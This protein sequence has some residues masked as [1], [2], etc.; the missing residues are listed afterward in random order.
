MNDLPKNYESKIIDAKW[1]QFWLAGNFFKADPSSTK[2]AYCIVMPPPNVTGCFTW[3]MLL[4][5]TLQD[6]LIRWKRMS[7]L[8]VLWVPGTDH[9]GISTQTVVEQHLIRT[10]R[11][12]RKDYSREEFLP[13]SGIGRLISESRYLNRLKKR[14]MF[15]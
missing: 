6:I 13:M 5:S 4:G 14:G 15:L 1:Y 10:D 3:A 12:K 11:K 7:W 2:P 9:A 8:E